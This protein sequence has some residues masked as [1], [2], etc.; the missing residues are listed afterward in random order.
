MDIRIVD[1]RLTRDSEV[2]TNSKNGLK[3]VTFTLANNSY[4][5]GEEV[6]TFFNVVSYN[7]YDI[8]R[9]ANLLKGMHVIVTGRP[10]ESLAV[11]DSKT[12]LN[13]NIIA[14]NIEK[15]ISTIIKEAAAAQATSTSYHSVAPSTP[16]LMPV[17]SPV[18]ESVTIPSVKTEPVVMDNPVQSNA[19]AFQV[20]QSVTNFDD[21]LPF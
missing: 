9:A 14:H 19:G 11:K 16:D 8:D 21:E 4:V 12:Y 5:K 18:V 17:A 7:E 20:S 6:A 15:G 10:T 13:R 2:K 3:F 1:G